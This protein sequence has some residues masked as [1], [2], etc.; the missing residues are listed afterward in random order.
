MIDPT[1][2]ALLAGCFA[3][4]FL[5]AALHKL[6]QPGAFAATFVAYRILPDR[7]A[8]LSRLVP[9]LVGV[10]GGSLLRGAGGF[11]SRLAPQWRGSPGARR[12]RRAA[13]RAVRRGA[14]AQSAARPPRPCLRLRWPE[15]SPSDCRLDGLAQP[16]SGAAAG[17][18]VVARGQQVPACRRCP[19]HRCRHCRGLTLIYESRGPARASCAAR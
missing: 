18:L 5:S 16:D 13:A 10:V 6:L 9:L 2:S 4:L 19:D 7:L 11:R 17:A 12:R 8:P 3:L 14:R 15:R 1:I